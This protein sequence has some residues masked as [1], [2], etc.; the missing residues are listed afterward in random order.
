M[1]KRP[2]NTW[3]F[4]I[5]RE[6]KTKLTPQ[7][8]PVEEPSTEALKQAREELKRRR[9]ET[10]AFKRKYFDFYDDVKISHREDW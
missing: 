1:P 4:E 5:K 7:N 6:D 2:S 9:Q 10:Q 8:E 3:N